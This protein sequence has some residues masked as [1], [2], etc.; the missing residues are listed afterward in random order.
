LSNFISSASD[1]K[2]TGKKKKRRKEKKKKK[3]K[4][5]NYTIQR[6]E[7]KDIFRFPATSAILLCW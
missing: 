7:T 5:N 6:N 2:K 4:I 1:R 3:E